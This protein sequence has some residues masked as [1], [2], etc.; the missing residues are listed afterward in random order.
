VTVTSPLRLGTRGSVLALTQSGWVADRIR[1]ASGRE[2]ELV[3]IRTTGDVVPDRPLSELGGRGIF[4][5]ELDQALLDGRIDIAVHS[6]KDLPTMFPE[7][8]VL[9]AIP[10]REDPR[11]VLVGPRGNAATLSGLPA[12]ARLGTGSL[13][14]QALARAHRPDLRIE[15]IRGNL[16]TRIQKVDRGEL[17][18]IFL[19]AAGLRR[20]G[21]ESRISE[22]LDPAAWPPAPG[23]GALAIVARAGDGDATRGW[24]RALNHA[25]TDA[26]VTS[27]R[28]LLHVLEAGCQLPVAAMGLP[29]DGGL[30][31][32]A[33]V[34]APDGRRVVRGEA[35]GRIQAPE[36]L[37]R[38]VAELLLAR[39]AGRILADVRAQVPTRAGGEG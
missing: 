2:V 30:R 19:A 37:G 31:L 26:A 33:M 16:D 3:T 7:G 36:E 10:E 12:G 28:T 13:R 1:H 35:T 18:G 5:R 8:L 6:L 38:Q 25:P 17:D 22:A 24:S 21:W 23:Q 20:L 32:R 34:A 27:E 14:R 9:A 39:G 4:T 11:D 15:D 29:F